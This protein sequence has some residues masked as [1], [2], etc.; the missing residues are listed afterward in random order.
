M[1]S[2]ASRFASVI[3]LF[4]L[5]AV[6]GVYRLGWFDISFVVRPNTS[7][8]ENTDPNSPSDSENENETRSE[9]ISDTTGDDRT[10]ETEP[11][12]SDSASSDVEEKNENGGVCNII[13]AAEAKE[14]G[15]S[16]SYGEW[17]PSGSWILA[18]ADADGILPGYYSETKTTEY[19]VS[20][21]MQADKSPYKPVY[22]PYETDKRSV[23]LYMGYIITE[24]DK[25]G[26]VNIY[27]SDLKLIGSYNE[28]EISPAWCRDNSDRPLFIYKDAYYYL[29]AKKGTFIEAD[30]IPERDSRGANFDYTPDYGDDDNGRTFE[31][32]SE[33][34]DVYETIPKLFDEEGFQMAYRIPTLRY[35]YTLKDSVG[36]TVSDEVFYGAYAFSE[37]RAAV[38][39]GDGH[40]YY[41]TKSGSVAVRTGKVRRDVELGRSV[42]DFYMEPITNGAESI[43]FYY[44]EH[45]LSRVRLLTVDYYRYDKYGIVY[46]VSDDDILIYANGDKFPT[47]VGYDVIAYSSG[48]ILLEHNGKYGY[49]DYTGDWIVEP[50]LSYA[51]PFYEGLAVIGVGDEGE[52]FAMINTDGEYVIPPGQFSYISNASSGVISAYGD[53][54][55]SILYKMKLG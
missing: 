40:L 48:M 33:I 44:F 35:L 4:L 32:S 27:S 38:I 22:T 51:E 10:D 41:I 39:D 8:S 2:T 26:T 9:N 18:S 12:K 49:M 36:N 24:T 46:T 43:G 54:G 30:Y 7:Y 16:R 45:G 53:D 29:D 20:Y 52:L 11:S 31:V 6:F 37:S 47:P 13:S 17:N 50:T 42:F 5:C 28:N 3:L 15:Y 25:E 55:W 1:K 14:G 34:Y 23:T 19:K 21:E